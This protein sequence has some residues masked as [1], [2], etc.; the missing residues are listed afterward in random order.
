VRDSRVRESV[1]GGFCGYAIK[2]R[3]LDDVKNDFDDV[4]RKKDTS[5]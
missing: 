3:L 2:D 4:S 5:R 1:L